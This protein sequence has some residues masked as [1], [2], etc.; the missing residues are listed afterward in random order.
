M[1]RHWIIHLR[2]LMLVAVPRVLDEPRAEEWNNGHRDDVRTEE[3]DDH[4]KRERGKQVL[5]DACKQ[6]DGK[7]DNSCTESS[8]QYCKLDFLAPLLR[9]LDRI[10]THLKVAEDIFEHD[11]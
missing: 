6:D 2:G 11:D 10:G 1:F 5:A 9:G 7:E 4:C 8:C 3:C